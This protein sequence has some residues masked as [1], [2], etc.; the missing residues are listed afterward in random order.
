MARFQGYLFASLLFG[1]T[2]TGCATLPE[3]WCSMQCHEEQKRAMRAER[4]LAG[5]VYGPADSEARLSNQRTRQEARAV[6]AQWG[7]NGNGLATAQSPAQRYTSGAGYVA[8][9]QCR[10]SIPAG[11]IGQARIATERR[12][13]DLMEGGNAAYQADQLRRTPRTEVIV[14]F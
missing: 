12:C 2:L 13:Y 7:S 14:R 4:P 6:A 10:I 5:V 11:V 9:A 1:L 8:V 3:D